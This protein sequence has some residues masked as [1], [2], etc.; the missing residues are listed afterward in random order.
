[1]HVQ[2]DVPA[3]DSTLAPAPFFQRPLCPQCGEA[4]FAATATSYF[5]GGRIRHSWSCE[6][7]RYEF[8]T[9]IEMPEHLR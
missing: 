7:C 4:M 5:G 9:A 2:T 6:I 3:F 8:E 1:M